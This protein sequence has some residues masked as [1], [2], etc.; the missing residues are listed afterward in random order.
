MPAAHRRIA[1]ADLE[2]AGGGI[3]RLEGR[4]TLFLRP[5][6][7]GERLGARDEG[8]DPLLEERPHRALEDE[9][10]ERLGRVEGTGAA[11]RRVIADHDDGGAVIFHLVFQQPLVDRA[12]LLDRKVTVVDAAPP[13]AL[14]VA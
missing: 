14:H 11:P 7:G 9:L 8:R 3:E 1:D 10:H 2:E 5:R 6:I 4:K 12:E 13:V